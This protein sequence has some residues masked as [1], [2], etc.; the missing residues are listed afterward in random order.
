MNW[1]FLLEEDGFLRLPHPRHWKREQ[2]SQIPIA[3]IGF[4]HYREHFQFVIFGKI[5]HHFSW[6][7]LINIANNTCDCEHYISKKLCDFMNE[8]LNNFHFA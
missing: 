5:Q 2:H 8:D 3:G 1:D 4:V 6:N 7:L